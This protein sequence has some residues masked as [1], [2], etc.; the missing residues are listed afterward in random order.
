MCKQLLTAFALL[1][2]PC[3][4]FGQ[5]VAPG[6]GLPPTSVGGVTSMQAVV[7]DA[8]GRQVGTT[9]AFASG[10][11]WVLIQVDGRVMSL[12]VMKSGIIGSGSG[13]SF[14]TPD[15]S[16]TPYLSADTPD[17][18][19][20]PSFI[21]PPGKTLYVPKPGSVTQLLTPVSQIVVPASGA[22]YC[23]PVLAPPPG[24]PAPGPSPLVQAAKSVDLNQYF[25]PPFSIRAP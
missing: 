9:S 7:V 25:L 24:V 10:P 15:C 11:A 8:Y 4:I 6:G 18:L 13:P 17:F 3:M 1:L 5:I 21:G 14:L 23:V 19:I 12:Q 22:P 16:G 20:Q 2:A